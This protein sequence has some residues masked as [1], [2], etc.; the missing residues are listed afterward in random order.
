M[1]KSSAVSAARIPLLLLPGLLNDATLWQAQLEAL[2]DI[3]DCQVGDLTRSGVMR[4]HPQP[5]AARDPTLSWG[6]AADIGVDLPGS[7][8]RRGKGSRAERT[9]SM[10]ASAS[11]GLPMRGTGCGVAGWPGCAYFGTCMVA[12]A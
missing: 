4:E 6:S 1:P 2:A 5:G 9:G 12:V 10:V 8:R 7:C 11:A 3:A